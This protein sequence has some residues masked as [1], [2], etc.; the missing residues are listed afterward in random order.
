V[1]GRGSTTEFRILGP[2]E[3][4]ENGQLLEVGRGKER[5]FLALLLLNV[6]EVVSTDRV[7]DALWGERPPSSALNSV[8]VYASHLRKALGNERL[9]TRGRGYVLAVEPEQVDLARFERLAAEGREALAAGEAERAS[10]LL[11]SAL[12][13]WHGA[14]LTD[15]ASEPFAPTEIARLQELRLAA[16]EEELDAD[17]ALGRHAEV[18]PELE[19]LVRS[20]PLRERLAA[21][22]M[23]ALYR[24]G[25]QAEALE[26]YRRTR[27][28]L[29]EELGLEPGRKL[30]GLERA[31]LSHDPQLEPPLPPSPP[32]RRPSRRSGLL[33]AIGAALLL[34]AALAVVLVEV[35]GGS[36]GLSSASANAVA[37][38]TADTN[39]L[40][41]DVPLGNGPISIAADEDAVWVTSAQDGSVARIDPQTR[42]IVEHIPIGSQ[43]AGIAINGGSVWV[44]SSLDGT[45]SRIDPKTNTVVQTIRDI[46]TP[47]AVAA[48]FG[49]VW[50]TSADERSVKRI[51]ADSGDVVDTIPT[52]ALGLGIAVGTGSVWVTDVS[53]RSVLRIDPV[54]GSVVDTVGVGNGPKGIAFGAGSVWVANSLDGTVS[55]IDPETDK[56]TAVIPVG[57]G[58]DGVAAEPDAVWVSS[59]FSQAIVRIDPAEARVVERIPVG[60]R[61]K[62]LAVFGDKV[63][64]AV[65]PSGARHRGGRLIVPGGALGPI[66]PGFLPH[67]VTAYDAL[68]GA[69][70]RGGSE[71]I[72]IVPN[73]ADSLPVVTAG[74]TRY[75]F[76]LR[77]DIRYSNGTIVKASDFRRAFER[78]FRLGEPPPS[79][80]AL[81]GADACKRRARSCD[82]RRGVQTGDTTGTIAFQLRR[83]DGEF[84]FDLLN[85]PAPV[86]PGTPDREVRTRPIP[87]TGPYMIERYVPG[88]VLRLVRNPYFHVRSQTARPDGFPDEIEFRVGVT[89]EARVTAVERGRADIAA[90]PPDRVREVKKHYAAQLHVNPEPASIRD[91][92][93]NTRLP[94]FDD[95]RVRRALN[96]AVD[97]AAVAAA[98]GGPELAQPLCQLRPPSIAGYRPYCP[99]TIEPGATGEWKAPDLARARRLV[100]ASGTSG[101]KVTLWTWAW[102]EPAA[103]QVVAALE[104]LGYRTR[105]RQIAFW[106]PYFSKVLLDKRTR[107]QAAM[108]GVIGSTGNPPSYSYV[109]PWL[110]CGATHLLNPGFFCNRRIDAEIQRALRI[111]AIDPK[112]AARSWPRIERELVDQAPLVP[113]FTPQHADLVSKRV[114][115]YQYNPVWGV[116]LDQLW[117]R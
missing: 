46:V 64:F 47:T 80:Q 74:G 43:P 102:V 95:V 42:S 31:I 16:L 112:A 3:V 61:P 24:S 15:F 110:T 75:A 93:L 56:V 79:F 41:A 58:P 37:L 12:G 113:L 25:R 67:L 117:V 107:V 111:Q 34:A 54:S 63:W 94:P 105:L 69:A 96:Y 36:P 114:G 27:R 100:A 33:I 76:T 55:R 60:N 115:N 85:G 84:L 73:L 86:P 53:S 51:D 91:V 14:P 103:R 57:E 59:E 48:G 108:S 1:A 22:L 30:Q 50:V 29:V 90:V 65:Q 26:T 101:M 13:L 98:Q 23:L 88:R 9:L 38:I 19:A 18:I 5:A 99:Y 78:V 21:Q 109:L 39:R 89:A 45:V 81:V 83:P 6:G 2:F 7:I 71:G 52:G 106:P 77:R 70:W 17:L 72:P 116:L 104:R 62:G 11:R 8:R 35:T 28:R 87:S 68:V 97:R 40:V 92:F 66:D 10:Q 44:A 32:R 4:H 20:N 49:S 82:L